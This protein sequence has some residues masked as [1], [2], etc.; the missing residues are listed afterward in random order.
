[1]ARQVTGH[2]FVEPVVF[3][4]LVCQAAS[5]TWDPLCGGWQDRLPFFWL[6][7]VFVAAR[8]LSLVAEHRLWSA[9]GSVVA[10]R[11]LL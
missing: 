4:P 11:R 2:R 3:F 6:L 10:V 9:Q 5:D 8:G 7:R 1:M